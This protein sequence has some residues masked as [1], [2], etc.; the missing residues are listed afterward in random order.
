MFEDQMILS[1]DIKR[2]I[3]Q[4]EFINEK[5]EVDDFQFFELEN[6]NFLIVRISCIDN[7]REVSNL[8][9]DYSEYDTFA[10]ASAIFAE[11]ID[12]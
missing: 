12:E 10:E 2:Q 11:L 8:L 4:K 1:A 6:G 5:D 3:E 7:G 9:V